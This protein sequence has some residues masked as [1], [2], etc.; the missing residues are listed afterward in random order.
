MIR[1]VPG[2]DNGGPT[3]ACSNDGHTQG[4]LLSPPFSGLRELTET[5]E[6]SCAQREV[7]CL[8]L[9]QDKAWLFPASIPRPHPPQPE[10]QTPQRTPPHR[11]RGLQPGAGRPATRPPTDLAREGQSSL[12]RASPPHLGPASPS[13]GR[14]RRG[15][16]ASRPAVQANTGRPGAAQLGGLP[17]SESK[18][19][20]GVGWA[21]IRDRLRGHGRG[22]AGD[23]GGRGGGRLR[24]SPP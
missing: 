1:A 15:H 24:S 8:E 14:G 17:S 20:S 21:R 6:G 19:L 2:R 9:M 5:T 11:A 12:A 13:L 4:K 22:P 10:S 16:S 3:P 18:V 7:V 23:A